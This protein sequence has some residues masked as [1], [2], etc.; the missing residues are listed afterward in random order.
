VFSE[1]RRQF[2]HISMVGFALALRYLTWWQAALCAL[3]ALAFN[4][5]VLPRLAGTTLSRPVDEARGYVLG[6]LLYPLAV[7]L[8]I[9]AFPTRPDIAAVAWGILACGDGVATLVG[10]PHG[11]HPLPWNPGKS[12]EGSLAFFGAAVI[13]GVALSWWTTAAVTPAPPTWFV[14]G[15]P[16]VAALVAALAESVPIHL[17]DNITVPVV[18]GATLWG[19][20]QVEGAVLASAMPAMSANLLA[21]LVVNTVAAT[22]GWRLGTVRLSGFIAGW[23]I[24]V[25]VFLGA[26]WQGWTLLFLT[27]LSAAVTSRLGLKRKSVLGIAEERGG[28][29]GAG[30]AFANTGLAAIAAAMAV[31]T[32]YRDAALLAF[33]TILATGGS[34]TIASEM[35]KA[36]GGKTYLVT[37]MAQVRPG[38]PGAMSLEGTA[39]GL[40]GAFV[41]AW[42]GALL[43]LVPG[44]WIWIAV[45][46]A[47]AGSLLESALAA[48]L[49]GAGYLNNDALNFLNTAAGAIV[50]LTLMRYV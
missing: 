39:A 1:T 47:C 36:W 13:A 11:R 43:G 21:A 20:S 17:D 33:V 40:V 45:A 18:A 34:D 25:V 44:A 41:L 9:L 38:T 7:L 5:L 46:G 14:F 27:F 48:T 31:C 29:R 42:I 12:V 37:T 35:G 50:A 3:A 49:E 19:L 6:I 15:A 8:L 10:R 24:G 23:V 2:I 22:A 32:P 16:I 30:N 26:G 28:R 4:A